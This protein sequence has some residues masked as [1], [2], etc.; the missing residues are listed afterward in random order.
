MKK[1]GKPREVLRGRETNSLRMGSC[2]GGGLRR[3]KGG[4]PIR[5]RPGRRGK[6]GIEGCFRGGEKGGGRVRRDHVGRESVVFKYA[7]LARKKGKE[8]GGLGVG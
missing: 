5:Q 2:F 6:E 1:G 8:G 4:Y 7:Y 3:K